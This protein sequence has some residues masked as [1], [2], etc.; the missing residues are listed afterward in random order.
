[1][2][3]GLWVYPPPPQLIKNN[4]F[5]L[6]TKNIKSVMIISFIALVVSLEINIVGFFKVKG[7]DPFHTI[8]KT[9]TVGGGFSSCY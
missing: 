5:T 4:S 2:G 8:V 6:V 7:P 3:T 1:M 9:H